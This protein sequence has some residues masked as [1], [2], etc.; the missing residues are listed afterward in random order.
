VKTAGTSYLEAVRVVARHDEALFR[1]I[2]D[3][4]RGHYDRDRATYHVS[5][6]VAELPAPA[7]VS[8]TKRLEKLYLECWA[9]VRKDR[10]FTEPGRQVLHCTFGT[11]LTDA[12]L[13]PAI[14]QLLEAHSATYTE[15]LADH[16]SRHLDALAKT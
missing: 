5:A 15:V 7:D 1:R 12:E 9:D 16:F 4:A 13:G 6:E 2:I 8:D 11:I 3:T 10:G 14:R